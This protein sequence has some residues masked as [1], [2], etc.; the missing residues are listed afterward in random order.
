MFQLPDE[1]LPGCFPQQ[2]Y[3]HYF[4]INTVWVFQ[5]LHIFAS[6]CLLVT[7]VWATLEGMKW[8][9]FVFPKTNDVEYFFNEHVFIE[10][11]LFPCWSFLCLWRM[12]IQTVASV[13]VRLF[14]YVLFS[15]KG[16]HILE[17]NS[18]SRYMPLALSPSPIGGRGW[19]S[20]GF[21]FLSIYLFFNY[22]FGCTGSEVVP[23]GI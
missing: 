13:L 19:G 10:Q 21:N 6:T 1:W 22:M 18:L 3:H 11:H 5:F 14:A 23:G 16:L 12:C 4:P 20:V 2:P 8:F 9:W 7:M 17:Y 15:H